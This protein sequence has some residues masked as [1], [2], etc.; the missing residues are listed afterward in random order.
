MNTA[1]GV[2]E[3]HFI[4]EKRKNMKNNYSKVKFTDLLFIIKR[5]DKHWL[6]S[7]EIAH[8]HTLL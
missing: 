3:W 7:K 5:G 1:F 6:K 4:G 8:I 2:L